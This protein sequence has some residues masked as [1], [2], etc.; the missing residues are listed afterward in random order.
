MNI[1][2]L[3]VHFGVSFLSSWG[4]GTI[5]NI[6]RRT[7]LPAGLTGA[8]AWLIYVLVASQTVS[9]VLPNLLAAITIGLLANLFAIIAKAPV[10]V[11]YIPC[12]VSLVPGALIYNSMKSFALG[13]VTA[14][15]TGLVQTL[16]IAVSLAVGFVIAE[17]IMSKIRPLIMKTKK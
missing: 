6:P 12:L 9:P 7:L 14:G 2:Q 1:G 15:Q 8:C 5:T 11:L 10:N 17:A 4:F 13:K 16:V 3:L